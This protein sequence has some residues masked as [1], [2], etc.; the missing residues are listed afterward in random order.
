MWAFKLA[1]SEKDRYISIQPEPEACVFF[2]YKKVNTCKCTAEYLENKY[3]EKA[4]HFLKWPAIPSLRNSNLKNPFGELICYSHMLSL[5]G[6]VIL[7]CVCSASQSITC[8]A[9]LQRNDSCVLQS[10]LCM[11]SLF[12]L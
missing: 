8:N 4:I 7:L 5:H 11:F 10:P 6:S 3:L 1:F 2:L 12:V 9:R